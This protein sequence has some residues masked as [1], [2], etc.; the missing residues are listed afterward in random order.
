[1]PSPA[2]P[3]AV[4]PARAARMLDC[5][6]AHIYQLFERGVLRRV[7]IPGSHAVRVPVSDIY[8]ALGMP[9]P[10]GNEAA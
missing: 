2:E 5:S 10:G 1:M 4:K 3:L 7:E 8:A 6:R 9:A